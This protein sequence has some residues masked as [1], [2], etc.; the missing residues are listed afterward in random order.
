MKDSK[1]FLVLLTVAILFVEVQVLTKQ[2][3]KNVVLNDSDV[4]SYGAQS[5]QEQFSRQYFTGGLTEGGRLATTT[6]AATYTTIAK[7]FNGTPT[8]WS[9]LPNVNTTFS[10]TATSTGVYVPRVGDVAQVYLLNASSTAAST[11]TLAALDTGV[12][13][14]F[15]EATGGDLVLN[16]LDWAKVTLIR[17]SAYVVTVIFDEMTEAD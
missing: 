11:I 15:A 4:P 8:L 1:I 17:K 5:G 3:V 9:V 14:Q 2:A 10:L 16:G 6:T 12:D 7:D 13:L